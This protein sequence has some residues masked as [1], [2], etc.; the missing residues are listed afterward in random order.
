MQPEHFAALDAL[1][2]VLA[3]LV[4]SQLEDWLVLSQVLSQVLRFIIQIHCYNVFLNI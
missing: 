1:S 3:N 2:I 4:L